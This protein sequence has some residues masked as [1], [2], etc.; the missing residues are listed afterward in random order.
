MGVQL[1]SIRKLKGKMIADISKRE[2]EYGEVE[3]LLFKLS[4]GSVYEMS[5]AEQ[6]CCER[7][8]V[9]DI[10]GELSDLIESPI[11]MAESASRTIKHKYKD[12]QSQW[13]FYK[14]GTIKG[15]VEQ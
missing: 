3:A 4:D 11:L 13:T 15:D 2:N 9:E 10:C 8:Y 6:D 1:I 14:I 5:H 7:V 12:E